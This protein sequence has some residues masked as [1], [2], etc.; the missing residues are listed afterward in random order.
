MKRCLIILAFLLV[1]SCIREDQ[2]D[3]L[4]GKWNLS[5]CTYVNFKTG[6]TGTI[7]DAGFKSWEFTEKG[8]VIIDGYIVGDYWHR[9]GQI[10]VQS[11]IYDVV[12]YGEDMMSL[13]YKSLNGVTN[14]I[15]NR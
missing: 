10:C 12:A 2:Q 5:S 14:Y 13:D 8:T 9:D 4:I 15:F 3:W 11:T 6:E 7:R 1:A